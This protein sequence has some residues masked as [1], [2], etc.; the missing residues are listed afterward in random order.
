MIWT[1]SG[2]DFKNIFMVSILL[3]RF[4]RID[5]EVFEIDWSSN[6]KINDTAKELSNY[7]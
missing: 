2:I 6:Q 5:K 7:R 1:M 4:H 3:S